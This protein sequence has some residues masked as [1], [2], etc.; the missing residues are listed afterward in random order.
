[1]RRVYY[2]GTIITMEDDIY[3]DY[4]VTENGIIKETGRGSAPEADEYVDLKGNTLMPS[5]YRPPQPYDIGGLF[6]FE[7]AA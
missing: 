5:I 4:V 3:A 1:M 7:G 2:N 6:V